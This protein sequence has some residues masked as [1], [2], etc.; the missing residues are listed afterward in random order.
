MNRFLRQSNGSRSGIRTS[1]S[2]WSAGYAPAPE[3]GSLVI[4]GDRLHLTQNWLPVPNSLGL[5]LEVRLKGGNIIA[6]G[7]A[8][9]TAAELTQALK[10][11]HNRFLYMAIKGWRRAR[12]ASISPLQGSGAWGGGI[13]RALPHCH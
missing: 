4:A 5:A 6:Q 11:R 12:P 9:G 2:V 13:P 10:G 3:L 7:N 8:L 1:V